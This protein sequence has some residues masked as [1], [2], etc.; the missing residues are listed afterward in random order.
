M[1]SAPMTRVLALGLWA[2]WAIAGC[3]ASVDDGDEEAIDE[4]TDG[5]V[6]GVNGEACVGSPY[7]CKLR[8]H[9][10]NAVD[11]AQGGLWT[12]N[13]ANVVDGN[14]DLIGPSTL[15][16]LR[17]QHGQDRHMNGVTYVFARTTSQHVAAW[18]PID[19]VASE[20]A[21]RDRLG[22]VTAKGAG[23]AEMGCYAIKSSHDAGLVEKKVVYDAQSDYERAGDYLPLPR[24]NGQRY[25][26][27]CF[28]VPGFGLGGPAIDIFPAGTKFRRLEVPTDTGR[29]SIDIPLWVKD[30]EGRYRKHSGNMRFIY[31]YI[32]SKTG[33][34]RNGWMS[35]EAV[36]VSSGCP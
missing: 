36:K 16:H 6:P 8:V 2:A 33:T 3:T 12:V 28:N 29:P 24:G 10:G 23:L 20:D 13:D 7:N 21:L 4:A 31:G 35:Y 18:F 22:E 1:P 19:A 5:L 30:G 9:G 34:R 32:E 15:D 25:A 14:G 26:N 17:F 27:L 11:N